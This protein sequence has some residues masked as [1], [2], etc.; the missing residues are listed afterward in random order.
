MATKEEK[1]KDIVDDISEMRDNGA[2]LQVEFHKRNMLG[3]SEVVKEQVDNWIR[4]KV[5]DYLV[6]K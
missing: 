2:A 4:E 3:L 5:W 1:R 6:I